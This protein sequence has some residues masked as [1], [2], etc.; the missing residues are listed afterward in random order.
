MMGED[1]W[2]GFFDMLY[3]AGRLE[4]AIRF[5]GEQ[6]IRVGRIACQ[7]GQTDEARRDALAEM[8]F[9]LSKAD[10]AAKA[11]MAK[12]EQANSRDAGGF[13]EGGAPLA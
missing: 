2:T 10:D 3:K 11:L 13:Q 8:R 4:D 1:A 9:C 5:F 12:R 6:A 7:V